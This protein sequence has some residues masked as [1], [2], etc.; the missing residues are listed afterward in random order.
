MED[1]SI[2][3]TLTNN[4]GWK[5]TRTIT[6][7]SYQSQKE[8][9]INELEVMLDS[10]LLDYGRIGENLGKDKGIDIKWRP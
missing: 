2:R 3:I 9:N 10:L 6:L 1:L 5:E 8:L 7:D 4:K